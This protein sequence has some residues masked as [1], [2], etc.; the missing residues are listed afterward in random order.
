M[1]LELQGY[2][3]N[4]PDAPTDITKI[5]GYEKPKEEQY[6]V[7]PY[8][9]S[10][11]EYEALTPAQQEDVRK[12]EIER[13]ILGFWFWNY[14]PSKGESEPIW[15]TGDAYFYFTHWKIAGTPPLFLMNQLEDFYFD[16]FCDND[17][18][19]L[20]SMRMKP[21]QE[22]CTQ[23]RLSSYVNNATL[24]F[25]QYYGIQSKTG[26]DAEEKNF[27][28]LVMS[29]SEIPHWMKPEVQTTSFPPHKALI[30]GKQ[31][32]SS[33]VSKSAKYLNSKIDWE[34]TVKNA[35]DGATL[36]K[37]ILDEGSKWEGANVFETWNILR[38]AL[39]KRGGKCYMLSTVGE[40]NEESV[41]AWRKLWRQ[42]NYE[43][44]NPNGFTD[45]GLYR[46]F[47]PNYCA[48]FNLIIKGKPVLDKYG[49]LD[50][51]VIKKYLLNEFNAIESH[52]DKMMWIRKYPSNADEALNYGS[53]SNV[54]DTF[55][56]TER[57]QYLDS[58]EPS[59]ERP[60]KYLKGTLYWI[61]NIRFG[62][63]GFRH[64][65]KGKWK[66]AYL[67]DIAGSE[68][69]NMIYRE[70]NI[71]KPFSHTPFRMGVDPFSYNDK[72][73]SEFSKGAFH[74]MIMSNAI[75]PELSNI[76][77]LEYLF[78]EKLAS[79]FYEDVALTMFFYGAKVNVERSAYS[80]G[81]EDFMSKHRLNGFMML[82]PDVTK[83]TVYTL[84]DNE[85]GTPSTEET[86]AQ[87]IRYIENYIANPN[88]HMNE[89]TVDNLKN[90]WF[91]D[92]IKQLM[93]YT[94]KNKTKFDLVA[95]L[96]HTMIACQPD[97]KVKEASKDHVQMRE[98]VFRY[99][100]RIPEPQQQIRHLA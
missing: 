24:N 11:D 66:I 13:R 28:Q 44:R 47:I 67:P 55:R 18:M 8:T 33:G 46:W 75:H 94:V 9:L 62:K 16:Y 51:P 23:R 89:N 54:F 81:L 42:S 77:C 12:T 63:V 4:I 95:S 60:V 15:M 65:E 73:G 1:V 6:W 30:F 90:L 22:G 79:M 69:V 83:K 50:I 92:T 45:S 21:R 27:D 87:G 97:K 17:P 5:F 76:I 86:I 41:E 61:D 3:I 96:I 93:D 56:L 99:M 52:H 34:A 85:I 2:N 68:R 38:P 20:G 57:L 72:E 32:N 58:F 84:K 59:E 70:N 25:H 91:E 82:R 88:P 98:K 71:I 43:K 48:K 78:R 26:G 35:Y 37:I 80:K 7:R 74:I 29:F 64:D 53:N 10:D 49:Y 19:C 100:F 40:T 31:R 39:E 14:N 36:N